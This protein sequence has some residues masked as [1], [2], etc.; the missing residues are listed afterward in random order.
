MH[1]ELQ[2]FVGFEQYVNCGSYIWCVQDNLFKAKQMK[3][4][5]L[6]LYHFFA[7]MT[8]TVLNTTMLHTSKSH[9]NKLDL[10]GL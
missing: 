2:D 7:I 6:H 1:E 8:H 4:F 3:I 9:G 10:F 5:S